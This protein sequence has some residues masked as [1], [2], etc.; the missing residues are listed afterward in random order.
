MDFVLSHC[1]Y[2]L[3]FIAM[4]SCWPCCWFISNFVPAVDLDRGLT[5]V[6]YLETFIIKI[7]SS[8]NNV[9]DDS[10]KELLYQARRLR[11]SLGLKGKTF[12]WKKRKDSLEGKGI[13]KK[14][15]EVADLHRQGSELVAEK[16]GRNIHCV[17][18]VGKFPV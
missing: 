10:L 6:F 3:W 13:C 14:N 8:L 11:Q 9:Q 2:I 18:T 5:S 16:A 7:F 1:T 15:K 17:P 12:L 4:M